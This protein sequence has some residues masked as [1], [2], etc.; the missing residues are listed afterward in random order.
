MS[1]NAGI[2]GQYHIYRFICRFT[3][4]YIVHGHINVTY[5]LVVRSDKQGSLHWTL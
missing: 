1:I 4:L 2:V 5:N 3:L